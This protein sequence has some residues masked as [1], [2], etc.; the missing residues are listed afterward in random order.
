MSLFRQDS[1]RIS[2]SPERGVRPPIN[3][4]IPAL[5]GYKGISDTETEGRGMWVFAPGETQ[6]A[7]KVGVSHGRDWSS[8][9]DGCSPDEM[10]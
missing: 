1:H 9:E 7:R 8:A 3:K 10:N 5:A 2:Q 6:D 4:G